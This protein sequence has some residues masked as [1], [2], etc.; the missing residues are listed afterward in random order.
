MNNNF[1][2]PFLIILAFATFA[3]LSGTYPVSIGVLLALGSLA[4]F[5]VGHKTGYNFTHMLFAGMIAFMVLILLFVFLLY[6]GKSYP[7]IEKAL[8]WTIG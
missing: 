8:L 3:V 5:G 1:R 7:W 2:I 4:L 6:L